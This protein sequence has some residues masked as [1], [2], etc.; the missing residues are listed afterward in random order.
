LAPAGTATWTVASR[1]A[2][3]P[4]LA[5]RPLSVA[6]SP[7]FSRAGVNDVTDADRSA[8]SPQR[9]IRVLPTSAM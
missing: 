4:A 3:G 6:V 1:V 7:V 9:T 8:L 2:S 5:T